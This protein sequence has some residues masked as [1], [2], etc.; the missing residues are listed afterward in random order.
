MPDVDLHDAQKLVATTG[1]QGKS[2]CYLNEYIQ[3]TN[4]YIQKS[5]KCILIL[6]YY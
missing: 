6:F 3:H 1:F 2:T 4:Q 5:I